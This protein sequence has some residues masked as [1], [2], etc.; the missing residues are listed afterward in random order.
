MTPAVLDS[1]SSEMCPLWVLTRHLLTKVCVTANTHITIPY[2]PKKAFSINRIA[3][4]KQLP[5]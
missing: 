3:E 4:N 1:A 5:E 2:S